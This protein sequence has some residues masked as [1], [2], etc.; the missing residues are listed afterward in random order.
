MDYGTHGVKFMSN[1]GKQEVPATPSGDCKRGNGV[2]WTVRAGLHWQSQLMVGQ[3][4]CRRTLRE[5][6]KRP[7][8]VLRKGVGGVG[9][10]GHCVQRP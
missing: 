5:S 7:N 4:T 9:T 8:G 10:Q 1:H 2:R 6:P 3:E